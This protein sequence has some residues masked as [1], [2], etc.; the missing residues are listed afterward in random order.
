MTEPEYDLAIVGAGIVGV[1]CALWAQ[2]RGL[3]VLLLDQN[4]PGSGASYGNACTVATYACV[5]VNSPSI[6]TSLPSLLLSKESPLGVDWL[7]ALKNLPWMIAFLRNCSVARVERIT[8]DLGGLLSYADSG[9]DPL[10]RE[11]GAEDLMVANDCLY[12]YSSANSYRAATAGNEARRRNGVSFDVLAPTEIKTLE[13]AL[14]MPI[15]KGLL[16]R[17]ARHVSDP[18]AL[19]ERFHTRFVSQGGAWRQSRVLRTM[20]G[21][22]GVNIGLEDGTELLARKA[23]IAAGAHAKA[24]DGSGVSDIPLDTE[25]GHHVMFKDHGH[26]LSRPVGWA[27]AGFYATP[28]AAGL[29]IAGTVELAGLEKPRSPRRIAYLTRKSHEMFGDLGAPDEDWL[30]FRP[31]LPDALPVIGHSP[32]SDDILYAFGHQHI[33]LTLGGIT[34]RIIADLAQERKPNED[35]SAFDPK[36]FVRR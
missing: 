18:Q 32:Q 5:P 4:P 31:T 8:D 14:K 6:L 26:L 29:R 15:H 11:A 12:V 21:D 10:I 2:M 30:G 27:D 25:R 28:M 13:P 36:R 23:V 33:G 35:I 16:F 34:G 19:V 9:L 1:S 20:S 7:Y 24:I 22:I 17:G 3:R